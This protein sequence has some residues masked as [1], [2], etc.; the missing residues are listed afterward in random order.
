MPVGAV[1]V[2]DGEILGKGCNR[3]I[4]DSDPSAHAE[5]N[6]LREAAAGCNNY[7]L[8]GATV[9]VTVEP[10]L[11]CAGALVHARVDRL[12][13]GASE[14]KAGT[15][16]SHPVLDSEFLNHKVEVVGSVLG[17]E[18]SE[19]MTTFFRERRSADR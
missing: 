2:R 13:Y 15:V 3:S 8:P 4:G 1:V 6:A 14:P 18:C 11:M 17:E 7:R 12:V 5:I 19:L 10:C 16:H 9:Y